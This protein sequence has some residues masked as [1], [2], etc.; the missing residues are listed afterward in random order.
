MNPIRV[1]CKKGPLWPNHN[2]ETQK[3]VQVKSSKMAVHLCVV[4]TGLD[5][6][7]SAAEGFI[8]DV[9]AG[10]TRPI[11]GHI[12]TY[13]G[14][15]RWDAQLWRRFT[16]IVLAQTAWSCFRLQACASNAYGAR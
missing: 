11:D 13:E 8:K 6:H 2:G 1:H 9:P 16:T 14:V 7:S 12:H 5:M 10:I 4:A 15:R 3:N